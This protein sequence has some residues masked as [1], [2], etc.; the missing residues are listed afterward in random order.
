MA[1]CHHV[2]RLDLIRDFEKDRAVLVK[3]FVTSELQE[4]IARPPAS[5]FATPSR[6]SNSSAA[7]QLKYE[8]ML[9]PE[10][11]SRYRTMSGRSRRGARILNHG[12]FYVFGGEE[13]YGYLGA[14]F[15]R[16]KDGNMAAL[17]FVELAA[18]CG[19]AEPNGRRSSR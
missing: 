19:G 8:R 12:K 1:P 18:L 13:S 2:L 6:D 3:T 4:A 5:G 10:I 16:D 11:Q 17:M 15:V 14:D 7:K 9:P